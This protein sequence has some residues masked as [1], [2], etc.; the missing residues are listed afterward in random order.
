MLG[1]RWRDKDKIS[2]YYC[3]LTKAQI[4]L[5][6]EEI[7]AINKLKIVHLVRTGTRKGANITIAT[8]YYC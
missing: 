1:Y 2:Y 6:E 5:S 3:N 7:K 4:K 8:G